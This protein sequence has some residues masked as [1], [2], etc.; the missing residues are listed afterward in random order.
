[1]VPRGWEASGGPDEGPF[2]T[3]TQFGLLH[4]CCVTLGTGLLLFGPKTAHLQDGR[5]LAHFSPQ[6][7]ASGRA[8]TG[9]QP[10]GQSADLRRVVIRR[11]GGHCLG[12]PPSYLQRPECNFLSAGSKTPRGSPGRKEQTAFWTK[13]GARAPEGREAAWGRI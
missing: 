9:L 11:K 5:S 10:P 8:A 3:Q 7:A 4:T 13:E 6:P 2:W 1:M 12:F